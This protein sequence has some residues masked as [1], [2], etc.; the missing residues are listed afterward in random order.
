[1]QRGVKGA[2][3]RR[4]RSAFSGKGHPW[5]E[6]GRLG[7]IPTPIA[8]GL[9][10][11][12][13]LWVVAECAEAQAR[14]LN[15]G[16]N[17]N[18][19][20]DKSTTFSDTQI[21]NSNSTITSLNQQYGLFVF[22]DAYRLGGYR[23]DVSWLDQSSNLDQT[24]QKS[25]FTV[26]DYRLT[27]NLF[28]VWSPL[29]LSAQHVERKSDLS[30]SGASLTS[31][32]HIDSLGANWVVNLHQMPRTVLNFQQSKLDSDSGTK[33]LTRTFTALSDT[34]IGNTHLSGGYQFSMADTNTSSPST[35][36]GVNLDTNT[37][38]TSS[39]TL[40]AY[41]R[42]AQRHVPENV[43]AIPLVPGGPTAGV[44]FF[45][46]RSLGTAL[47]YRP[48]L[49]WWDGMAS[50]N[51]TE[52]PYFNDFKSQSVLGV[53]NL[54]YDEKTD[55]TFDGRYLHISV[56]DST[57]NS[58]SADATLNYRPIFGLTTTLAGTAGLTDTTAIASPSTNN[59]FQQYRYNITYARPWN[60]IQYRTSYQITYGQST[61]N[62]TGVDSRDLGNYITLGADNTNTQIVHFGFNTTYSNIQRTTD[63]VLTNQSTYLL[64]LYGDSS[65]YRNLVLN[66]DSLFLR[67]DANYS[68][69]TGFGIAGK[70]TSGD[71]NANYTT[72]IGLLLNG[73]YRIEKYPTELL[74]DRQIFTGLVQ[75]T[76]YL[77]NNL[78]LLTTV[79]DTEEDNRYRPDVNVFE[80]DLILN[81]QVGL[82]LL[83]VQLQDI[84]TRTSGDKYG[85]R[86]IMMRASRTF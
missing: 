52:T 83:G 68:D 1:M 3:Y 12:A 38:L 24:N 17:L 71:L 2:F 34:T 86:S 13:V 70:V 67:G 9:W 7:R 78:N 65:Y 26:M 80:G 8:R 55:S 35:S 63:T 44:S 41:G 84:E 56:T 45:Q 20:Y 40:T 36:N 79:K 46:E 81:Y 62:P 69:T 75:Y 76:T 28:P 47:I 39:L 14:L 58:E 25:R 64:Q 61:T 6:T 18:I 42:Y 60:L 53:A 33:Y 77:I 4:F 23:A 32:D 21:N 19:S 27:F 37:Q 29:N 51:Y 43:A 10:I 66:G 30:I 85:T 57:I 49:Y 11:L 54:R 5:K 72:L 48:P 82:L 16:G 59:L 15:I 73:T 74:L 50:Y 31:Q 22:G